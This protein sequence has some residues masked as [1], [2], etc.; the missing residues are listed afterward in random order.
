[1]AAFAVDNNREHMAA[2]DALPSVGEVL[3]FAAYVA[4]LIGNDRLGDVSWDV[5]QQKLLV[6]VTEAAHGETVAHLLGLNARF[7]HGGAY[8]VDDFSFW[9]GRSGL[10][11]VLIK[12]PLPLGR[13]PERRPHDWPSSANGPSAMAVA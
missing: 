5:E 7:D 4:D 3:R 9:G 8:D 6:N 2:T 1:M 10:V 13:T 12:A 11:D